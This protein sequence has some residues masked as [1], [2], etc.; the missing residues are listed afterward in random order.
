MKKNIR[1]ESAFRTAILYPLAVSLIIT[2]LVWQWTLNP[3]MGIQQ[4]VRNWGFAGFT[5][6]WI[7]RPERVMYTVV[8]ASIWQSTGFYMVLMPA[9]LSQQY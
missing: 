8:M 6:D 2:G 1:G 7:V 3:S 5:F 9:G 4:F